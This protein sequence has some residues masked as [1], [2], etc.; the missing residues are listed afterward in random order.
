MASA[1]GLREA[2]EQVDG[3]SLEAIQSVTSGVPLE[4]ETTSLEL[5]ELA[6][7]LFLRTEGVAERLRSAANQSRHLQGGAP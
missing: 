6:S 7:I 2:A 4:W 1:S 5:S 3:L